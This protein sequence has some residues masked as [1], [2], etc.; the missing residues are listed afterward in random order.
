MDLL[1]GYGSD[2]SSEISVAEIEAFPS[3]SQSHSD[4]QSVPIQPPPHASVSK[5]GKR[6]VS[7][8][9]V[10]PTHLLELLTK[11]GDD[12]DDDDEPVRDPKRCNTVKPS[13]ASTKLGKDAGLSSLLSEL[14]SVRKL[15]G[16]NRKTVSETNLNSSAA[17]SCT[18]QV[19][20]SDDAK[21]SHN[22]VLKANDIG[23]VTDHAHD[24]R[25]NV[26]DGEVVAEIEKSNSVSGV[27]A[28]TSRIHVSVPRPSTTRMQKLPSDGV[29][30]K[31][32]LEPPSNIS[33]EPLN[34][35][36]NNV[37][38]ADV[39]PRHVEKKRSRREIEKALRSG[40]VDAVDDCVSFQTVE[41]SSNT[42][43]L[44]PSSELSQNR[45]GVRIAPV[46]MYDTKAGK[47]V[48]GAGVSGKAKSKNQINFLMVSAA[49]Y[50]ASEAQKTR[51]KA[52][53]AS[54]KRKYGW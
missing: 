50:E 1:G 27:S 25:N 30:A 52:H 43:F 48:L 18:L 33:P 9:A 11:G 4:S 49:A 46:A 16:G 23:K 3:K 21:S 54:A 8:H 10:L 37:V 19:Q 45:S 40:D 7:L 17:D 20:T 42:Y 36:G 6:L 47:D 53:R 5:R 29:A 35:H 12:S 22:K 44:D 2:D 38:N 15:T 41:A 39:D 31:M 28:S 14:S 34:Y 51:M 13:N 32:P 24:G 26:V